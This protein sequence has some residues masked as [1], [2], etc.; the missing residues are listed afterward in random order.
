[1]KQVSATVLLNREIVAYP[2]AKYYLMR[3]AAPTIA[4]DSRPGQ[5]LM[6]KCDGEAL[7]RRPI[8]IHAATDFGGIDLLY[9]VPDNTDIRPDSSNS[10]TLTPEAPF[11]KGLGARLLAALEKGV[12]L[13]VIGPLG[14]GFTIN[15]S[16]NKLLMVAGGIGVAPLRFLAEFA[17]REGNSVTM[18]LGARTAAGLI[19]G[20]CL[21][22]SIRLV[23]A[24]EDGTI[25]HQGRITEIVHDYATWADQIFV[26]G[27]KAMGEA[28]SS[29]MKG[30]KATPQTQISLETR[31]GCGTGICYSCSIRTTTGMKRVCK[32]GPV[33]DIKDIIWQEV[34]T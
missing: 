8:S 27:P 30:W 26:C 17:L 11:A 28:L 1:V 32:E 29:Q 22:Q 6:L 20:D 13:D 31:M 18:L 23:L 21:P 34:R 5:F 14:N 3:I 25:G 15:T 24:T 10:L 16:S 19:P 7:L 33:F 4:A 2:G 12:A 9:A